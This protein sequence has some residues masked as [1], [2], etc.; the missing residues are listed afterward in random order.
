VVRYKKDQ[1]RIE[2]KEQIVEYIGGREVVTG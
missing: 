1:K 2:K